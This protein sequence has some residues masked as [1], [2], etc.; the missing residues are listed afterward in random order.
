MESRAQEWDWNEAVSFV[1]CSGIHPRCHALLLLYPEWDARAVFH[2]G[3]T[4]TRIL[5]LKKLCSLNSESVAQCLCSLFF[6]LLR[7]DCM[8]CEVLHT[9]AC[10]S[11]VHKLTKL[12]ENHVTAVATSRV[13][14]P[15][16]KS[17]KWVS[18]LW[19]SSDTV[20]VYYIVLWSFVV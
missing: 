3:E 18:I 7:M 9:C 1:H 5:F 13:K 12:T 11:V 4:K 17:Q 10:C 20:A 6:F 14:S 15:F 19:D 2:Q 16:D 8:G